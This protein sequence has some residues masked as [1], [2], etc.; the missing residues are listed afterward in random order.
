MTAE[1]YLQELP[2]ERRAVVSA[3]REMILEN[4]PAGYVESMNW[5][6]ISYE[7]PLETYPDTYNGQPLAYAGLAAQKNHYSLYLMGVYADG[8]EENWL[9]EQYRKAG[10][11]LD[12]GKSCLRFRKLE[13]L[14]MDAV[15]RVV[16]G[17]RPE[18]FIAAYE[19]NHRK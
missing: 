14:E 15:A 18:E 16:S 17:T 5:G 1:E 9:R 11:K 6:M 3:V 2:P 10:K 4:L 12:M 19:A 8:E 7:I 13:D